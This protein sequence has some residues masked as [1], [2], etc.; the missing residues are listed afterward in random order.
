[1]NRIY[2]VNL[3]NLVKQTIDRTLDR[4]QAAPYSLP[5][6]TNSLKH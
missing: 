6:R 2:L 1:M 4:L 5:F 3:V